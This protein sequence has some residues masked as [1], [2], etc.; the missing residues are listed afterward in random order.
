[1][2]E[3]KCLVK[4]MHCELDAAEHQNDRAEIFDIPDGCFVPR[5]PVRGVLPGKLRLR[6]VARGEDAERL[7]QRDM[8]LPGDAHDGVKAGVRGF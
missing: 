7:I 3:I 8:Q 5:L 6:A 4:D 1:M 2:Q